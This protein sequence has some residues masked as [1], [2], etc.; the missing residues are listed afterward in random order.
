MRS[1]FWKK[2]IYGLSEELIPGKVLEKLLGH[3]TESLKAE[4]M[5]VVEESPGQRRRVSLRCSPG[6]TFLPGRGLGAG[7][8][9]KALTRP[10]APAAEPLC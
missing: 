8:C 2:K 1:A 7:T 4:R 3:R 9:D 6:P 10:P 5:E